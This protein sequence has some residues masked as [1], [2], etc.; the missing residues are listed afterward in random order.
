M[1]NNLI[2][3]SSHAREFKRRGSFVLFTV[4]AYALLFVIGGVVSIYAYDA[5]LDQQTEEIVT[6]LLPVDFPST[7][8]TTINEPAHAP[9]SSPQDRSPYERQTA[10]ASV[11]TPQLQPTAVSTKPNT[12]L[13]VPDGHDFA[14]TGRDKDGYAGPVGPTAPSTAT[15]P[16]VVHMTEIPPPPTPVIQ[17]PVPLVVRKNIINGEAVELP[18]PPYPAIAKQSHTEGAVN[19]QVLI[20]ESG[21]VVS[22]HAV[23][24]SP[25]LSFEAVKAAYRARFSPTRIGDQPVKVSG[26]I[27]YNFVLN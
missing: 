24:G 11:N 22:A 2:E 10:M 20:D 9:K 13:P 27:T 21:K 26:I 17:K 5:H 8:K 23:S 16:V 12:A 25:L 6:M 4:G 15:G 19:V 7:P 3:S 18:T 1:F 14:I